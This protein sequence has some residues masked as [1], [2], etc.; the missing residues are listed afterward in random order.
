[1]PVMSLR[2]SLRGRSKRRGHVRGYAYRTCALCS[3]RVVYA[4]RLAVDCTAREPD[5]REGS[6]LC[7]GCVDERPWIRALVNPMPVQT[8]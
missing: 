6:P 2:G 5:L 7:D 1:M 3:A 8:V 4:S